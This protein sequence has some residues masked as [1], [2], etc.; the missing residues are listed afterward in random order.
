ML[1]SYWNAE[2]TSHSDFAAYRFDDVKISC[3]RISL[4]LVSCDGYISMVP[5]YS[6]CN[7]VDDFFFNWSIQL[8]GNFVLTFGNNSV[9]VCRFFISFS[10]H[11]LHCWWHFLTRYYY[12][13]VVRE[14]TTHENQSCYREWFLPRSITDNCCSAENQL[15]WIRTTINY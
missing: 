14:Y 5:N 10:L 12:P 9:F 4:S 15:M 2:G 13:T 6:R 8:Y 11:F 7:E 1:N 3:R